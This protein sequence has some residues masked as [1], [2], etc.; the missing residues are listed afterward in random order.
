[1]TFTFVL[2]ACSVLGNAE[3]ALAT[4]R[5]RLRDQETAAAEAASQE[6]T[7]QERKLV[8]L[9]AAH[10]QDVASL[11]AGASG[12]LKKLQAEEEADREAHEA[13]LAAALKSMAS[14]HAEEMAE[15]LRKKEAHQSAIADA[16]ARLLAVCAS[17]ACL[18]R[19]PFAAPQRLARR[20]ILR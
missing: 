15:Q 17:F 11:E 3:S 9:K 20:R 14:Q 13:R 5:E 10:E 4:A 16:K 19:N 2:F 1:M 7:E 6:A 8:E 12:Q 18:P